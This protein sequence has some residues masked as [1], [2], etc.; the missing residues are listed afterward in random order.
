[1][2]NHKN[3][4]WFNKEGD[5]LNFNYNNVTDRFEGNILFHENSTDTFKT[6][7]LYMVE[8]LPAFEY[9]LPGELTISKFQLFNEFG[10]H[11][12]SG[13]YKNKQVISI[14]PVNN[15]PNFYSKWIFGDDFEKLFP[16]GTLITFDFAFLEFTDPNKTY[17]V[18]GSK[19]GAIM[20]VSQMDNATFET[21]YF[22]Q[23]SLPPYPVN[24]TISSRN[25]IG[26][27]DY[28]D[29]NYQSRL[30]PWSEPFF[31][32]KF[33]LNKKLNLVKTQ[34]QIG[35]DVSKPPFYSPI[36]VTI[37]NVDLTDQTHFEYSLNKNNL[38]NDSSLIIEVLTRMDLSSIYEGEMT[39][40]NDGKIILEIEVPRTLKPGKEIKIINSVYNTNFYT[41]SYIPEWTGLSNQTF[42]S[43]QSQVIYNNK[44]YE[45]IQAYTQ[46]FSNLETTFVNP[47]DPSYWKSSNFIPVEQS[48]IAEDILLAQ[49]YYTTDKYYFETTFT[50]SRAVT[51]ASAAEKWKEDLKVFNIDLFYEKNILRADLIYPSKYAVVNFYQTQVGS[52]YSIG[53]Q[54]QTVEKIVGIENYLNYEL[55]YDISENFSYNI[56]FTDIDEYGLKI[57]IN[58]E[59]YD[60]EIVLIYTGAQ[61]DMERTIDATLRKWLVR[62]YVRLVV[63]GIRA[64]LKYI[65]NYTSIFYNSIVLKTEYPNVPMVINDVKVGE[66]AKFYIEHS[67]VIFNSGSY[68][69]PYINVNING[70]DYLTQAVSSQGIVNIPDTLQNWVSE[71]GEFLSEIGYLITN[72]NYVLKFD[73]TSLEIPLNYKVSTGRVNLPGLD[74]YT[75]IKKIKGNHG[76]MITSN[77]VLLP[78]DSLASFESEGF[79][80]GRVISINNT[81]F[82][83]N[84]QEYNIQFLDPHVMNLSYQG[85]FWGLTDSI[86]NSSAFVSLA[87]DTGFGQTACAVPGPTGTTGAGP[88]NINAFSQSAFS[89]SFNPNTYEI[90]NID[91]SGNIGSSNLVDIEYIQI[92]NALYL[93][94]DGVNVIDSNLGL[95]LTSIELPGNTQSIEME[96]NLINNYIYCLSAQQINIIDPT[97][98]LLLYNL[99]LTASATNSVAYDMQINPINGDVYV[100]YSNMPKIDIWSSDNFTNTPTKVL[101]SSSQLFPGTASGITRTGKMVFNSFEGD[102]YATT[103]ANLVLRINGSGTLNRNI[104]TQYFISGLTHSIFYEPV[105]ESI[106]VYGS[107]SL[108]KIDNGLAQSLSITPGSFNEIIFNNISNQMNISDN[109][110]PYNSGVF[111]TLNL[112]SNS[113]VQNFIINY[114]YL[115]VNQFDGDLY[116][117]SQNSNEMVIINS[118][119]GLV[120]SILPQSSQTG[121]LVYN[122]DRKS[123]WALQPGIN[124]VVE[125]MVDLASTINLLPVGAT[126][127]NDN[128]YGTL[129]AN[130]KP[131]KNIWIK[132][133]EYI[134]R[135]RENYEGDVSV[136]YYYK[137]VT[138]YVPEF[139]MYDFSGDQLTTDGPYA[140]VGPKPIEPA[141]LNKK[142]NTDLTKIFLPE[143][144]QTIF[145]RVEWTLDYIDDE[146]ILTQ[147]VKPL[148][149]FIGFNSTDEGVKYS[150]LLLMKKEEIEFSL[151][152]DDNNYVIFDTDFNEF[153]AFGTIKIN[154]TSSDFFTGRGLKSGQLIAILL[155]DLSNDKN[156]YT[157]LNNASIF[158]I[159]EVYSKTIVVDYVSEFGLLIP[160]KTLIT[161]FPNVGDKTYLR[162]TMR[163]LEKEIGRFLCYA[164]TEDEDERFKI[165]LGNIGRLI[166]PDEVFIFK[167]YDILEGGI[168]WSIL[169]RKRKEMLMMKHLIYPYIGS[170]KAL[171]NAINY[172]GYNDL[173]L[174]EYFR[175]TDT[176]SPNFDKNFKVRIPDIFDNTVE[177]WT[178]NEFIKNNF[179]NERYEP[180]NTFNLSYFITDEYGNNVINYSLDEILIKLQGLKYWLER[181]VIPLTHKISDIT[182]QAYTN[183][184]SSIT[185]KTTDIRIFKMRDE[186]CP[187]TF[188]MNELYLMPVTSGSTVYNCVLDFYSIIPGL[189]ASQSLTR[190]SNINNYFFIGSEILPNSTA[191][192]ESPDY[193]DIKIKTYKTYKEWVPFKT[194]EIGDKVT[195]YGRIYESVID[196]NRIKNPRKYETAQNWSPNTLYTTT[197]VVQ[198]D[199]DIYVFSGLGNAPSVPIPG[200]PNNTPLSPP[201]DPLNWL[202]ITEWKKID[203]EPVQIIKEWRKGTDLLPF[204]FTIDSNIDPYLVIEV[205]SDNGYG[206][207]YTDKKNY[208]VRGIKDLQES[209]EYI[210]PIGPFNPIKP[211]Y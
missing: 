200:I 113:S 207:T 161:D 123:I 116:L 138:D 84:N 108:W 156:Q 186:M 159:R 28:I 117:S 155:K 132:A 51:L 98:N 148:E 140:Y 26:V 70:K 96:F 195:Y 38:P 167:E 154:E 7:G 131:R 181:N 180:T 158:K 149:L 67:Q 60:E 184:T 103:D 45:C 137:W 198:Y 128:Q 31:Y 5:Y 182:G 192:L 77:E 27:Y 74:D 87:F 145:D 50:Q 144:Q 147:E 29:S 30:S 8:K 211:V 44:I 22:D 21:T 94:G 176:T 191:K 91:L 127:S 172:F 24:F 169:N 39:I 151:N 201:F 120:K 25:A 135:P 73:L 90:E 189:G 36:P 187:V 174:N 114:G 46:S 99:S 81:L 205:T 97:S 206:Q 42:F 125:I 62:N 54:K 48:T 59:L 66:T 122:P 12:Y 85:P 124:S 104:Q 133:K 37:D 203:L 193:F 23:Y 105:N 157:S 175:D 130:Y 110:G 160:E 40:T 196:N 126:V 95:Y 88:Y 35:D 146:N 141:I 79:A 93:F 179:P 16:L 82:P 72:I 56:V 53:S 75:I 10:L 183:N 208:E 57:F 129:D 11:I 209:Y 143:Y 89:I 204:N 168:D 33:Y 20:I 55:N 6:S 109:T 63:L 92:S 61:I 185:H 32:D 139:F 69:M 197:S 112:G 47:L 68:S 164:Q 152:A 111:S 178:E 136:Q 18:V 58:K 80:T 34:K 101:N 202:K 52:S 173:V 41:V 142:A 166:N 190:F 19:K 199:R 13:K 83:W 163:V 188:K 14:S 177:G 102:M 119:T 43:T 86:C 118:I 194:Y 78:P 162:F 2:S 71:H 171:I 49:I 150:E 9:E 65:G 121:R 170:Y 15:D 100:S 153:G 64:E 106:Y 210:D 3:L 165:E 76:M 17:T 1:M 107:S 134:R 4:I 115:E